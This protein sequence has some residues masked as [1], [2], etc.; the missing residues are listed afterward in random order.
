[1]FVRVLL[2]AAFAAGLALAQGGMGGGDGMGGPGG[3]TGGGRNGRGG[4]MGADAMGGM[5]H[6]Q[7]QSRADVVADK[8]RLN[9]EQKEQFANIV[10]AGQEEMRPIL[11][12]ISQGRNV[13][14]TAIIQGK[15]GDEI[16]KL[17]S[18][19]TDLMAQRGAAEA[20]AYGK[21]YAILD[22]KQQAKAAPVFAS[23]MDGLF[24]ARGGGRSGRG[25][26]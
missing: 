1:M 18:Q 13:I 26:Q 17:M 12:Q 24:E 4:D 19:F 23:E 7:R 8:L 11:Q 6:Q 21:L 14:V 9:K 20:K 22:P 25:R 3:G 15:T 5:P 16:N 10:S 2:T